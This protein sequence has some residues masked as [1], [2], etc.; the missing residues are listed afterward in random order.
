MEIINQI[1]AFVIA[2]YGVILL[3]IISI[4]TGLIGIFM[5]VPGEQPEKFF[6][7]CVDFLKKFSNK[8]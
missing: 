8:P 5:L 7:S 2:N 3:S 4:F 6:Q 1:I